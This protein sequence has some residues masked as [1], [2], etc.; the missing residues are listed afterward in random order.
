MGNKTEGKKGK[1]KRMQKRKPV[2]LETAFKRENEKPKRGGNKHR[3]LI[4]KTV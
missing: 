3:R 4:R 1:W 2:K